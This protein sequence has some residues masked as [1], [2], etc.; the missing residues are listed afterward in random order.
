MFLLPQK[1]S[2]ITIK[3]KNLVFVYMYEIKDLSDSLV[4]ILMLKARMLAPDSPVSICNL[5]F[6]MHFWAKHCKHLL[7]S[8]VY[9]CFCH[10]F[11]HLLF[12]CYGSFIFTKVTSHFVL[13]HFRSF[14]IPESSIRYCTIHLKVVVTCPKHRAGSPYCG[15]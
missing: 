5:S 1:K 15:D 2:E 3:L 11:L 4:A 8:I 9:F 10:C 12:P 13:I 14:L 7:L 6:T